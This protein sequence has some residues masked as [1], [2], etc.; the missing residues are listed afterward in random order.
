MYTTIYSN[1]VTG[2]IMLDVNLHSYTIASVARSDPLQKNLLDLLE[3]CILWN[4]RYRRTS[5]LDSDFRR[6]ELPSSVFSN[7][8]EYAI[9][10]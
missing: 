9:I 6:W 3:K 2:S 7:M 1:V 5:I 8:L 10:T 4:I